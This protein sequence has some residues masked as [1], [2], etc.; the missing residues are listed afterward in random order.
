[1]SNQNIE[2][3]KL[4]QHEGTF[5][6]AVENGG[7]LVVSLHATADGTTPPDSMAIMTADEAKEF[8]SRLM[9][10]AAGCN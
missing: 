7:Y 4:S 10:V 2:M 9:T 8:A 3:T 6:L 1:M 5:A